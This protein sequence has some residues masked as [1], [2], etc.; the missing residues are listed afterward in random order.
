MRPLDA[1]GRYVPNGK[2]LQGGSG[3]VVVCDDT[4]LDRKVAVKT[5]RDIADKNRLIDEIN[6]LLQLRSKHVVQVYDLIELSND[7]L[8][9]VLEYIDGD[10]LFNSEVPYSSLND[11]LKTLWQVASGLSDIHDQG[12]IH[13][14]IKPNNIK[15]DHEGVLI[16]YDFGLSRFSSKGASTIGFKGTTGFAAPELY[17]SGRVPFTAAVDV[18][19]FGA[20]AIYLATKGLPDELLTLPP[21]P[22]TSNPFYHTP[23]GSIPEIADSIFSC[24]NPV[25]ASRPKM[26][27]IRDLLAKYLLK[28]RHQALV[29]IDGKPHLINHSQKGAKLSAPLGGLSV[30]YDG[31]NFSM[32]NI[33]GHISVNG[34]AAQDGDFLNGSCV[35]VVGPDSAGA[36]RSYISFDVSHPEVVL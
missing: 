5:L 7:S 32:R 4:H 6:A 13:R 15:I 24:L 29:V 16:I 1:S 26:T 11:F 25:P 30:H 27:V 17:S 10:D 35:I 3:D 34:V 2:V 19:A 31:L 8:G 9:V 22:L 36:S 18:Y 23:L 28:D 14:D 12:I 20:T 21:H 33:Q